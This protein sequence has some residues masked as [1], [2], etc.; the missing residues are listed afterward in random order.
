[1]RPGLPWAPEPFE[2]KNLN[3][4]AVEGAHWAELCDQ[5]RKAWKA[6]KEMSATEHCRMLT[7]M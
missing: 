2:V 3:D 7:R 6:L 5:G 1:M 4:W